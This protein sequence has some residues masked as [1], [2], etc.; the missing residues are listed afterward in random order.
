MLVKGIQVLWRRPGS[1]LLDPRQSSG[2]SLSRPGVA[3]VH[4]RGQSQG[5]NGDKAY[6]SGWLF[7][8]EASGGVVFGVRTIVC[9]PAYSSARSNGFDATPHDPP[10]VG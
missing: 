3:H 7:F 6:F 4:C 5:R 1:F 10:P 2:T 9:T 8:M